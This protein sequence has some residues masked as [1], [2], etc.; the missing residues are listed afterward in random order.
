MRPYLGIHS[1]IHSCIYSMFRKALG[2]RCWGLGCTGHITPQTAPVQAHGDLL[3]D[4]RDPHFT[5]QQSPLSELRAVHGLLL[6]CSSAADQG[7]RGLE[8]EPLD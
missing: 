7:R 6:A 5:P 2:A 3:N 4:T 8:R 1:F